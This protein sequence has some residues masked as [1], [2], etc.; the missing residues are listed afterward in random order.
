MF[1]KNLESGVL[2]HR[3]IIRFNGTA[4]FVNNSGESGGGIHAVRSIVHCNRSMYF[5]N[6]RVVNY[7][8][9]IFACGRIVSAWGWKNHFCI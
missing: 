9:G 7:G 3:S 5:T 8:G 2:P 6:D 1:S 4:S